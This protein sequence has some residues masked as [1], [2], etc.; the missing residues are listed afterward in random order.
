MGLYASFTYEDL[1]FNPSLLQTAMDGSEV[2][3]EID[4]APAFCSAVD[5][6]IAVATALVPVDTGYL[7]ST[8]DAGA[9]AYSAWFEASAEYAQYPEF[10]TWCQEEQPYFR[11]ALQQAV[12]IFVSEAR[13]AVNVA[14]EIMQGILED[15]QAMM[16]AEAAAMMGEEGFFAGY[17][18]GGL[19]GGL[20]E[21]STGSFLMGTAFT[22]G[23]FLLLFP[24][25]AIG[26]GIMDT[27]FNAFTGGGSYA[28]LEQGE[29]GSIED[30]IEIT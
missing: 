2:E 11:P 26:Y 20:A 24:I 17:A 8:I 28:R 7:Q 12:D 22:A 29:Y 5:R 6:F 23:A 27:I 14:Q 19:Q 15:I 3:V 30:F 10:G 1:G 9:D 16:Y 18:A 25:L 4:Y 21:M 13:E